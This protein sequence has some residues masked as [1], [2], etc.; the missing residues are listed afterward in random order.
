MRTPLLALAGG[1]G[2][3]KLALGLSKVLTPDELTVVVNT[4]DDDEFYGLHV[5]PDLDTVTY[6][7]A[8][9]ANPETG[10][11]IAGDTFQALQALEAYGAPA[12]FNLGDNDLATHLRRTELLKQGLTLSEVTESLRT[13]LGV[14]HRIV[15]MSDDRVRTIIDTENGELPFQVY[16]VKHRFQ[17][18]AR[19]LRFAGA[20]QARPAP[21]FTEGAGRLGLSGGLSVEPIP[22]HRTDPGGGVRQRADRTFPRH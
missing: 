15:P 1:V 18:V 16:F 7:L 6:T 11:G 2:G 14:K 19:G 17:P 5:S 4:G 21:E 9:Q 22:Q 8:G 20:E 10:W 12:W 13:A 3:A